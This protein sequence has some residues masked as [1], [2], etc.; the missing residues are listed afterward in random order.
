VRRLVNKEYLYQI[1]QAV[2]NPPTCSA[3]TPIRE[4]SS[5]SFENHSTRAELAFKTCKIG[6]QT[7]G[8]VVNSVFSGLLCLCPQEASPSRCNRQTEQTGAPQLPNWLVVATRTQASDVRPITAKEVSHSFLLFHFFKA[9]PLELSSVA[10][11]DVFLMMAAFFP[12]LEN[13]FAKCLSVPRAFDRGH[14]FSAW[15][16]ATVQVPNQSAGTRR[17]RSN[18]CCV[19]NLGHSQVKTTGALNAQARVKFTRVPFSLRQLTKSAHDTLPPKNLLI[20]G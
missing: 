19:F 8:A 3:S 12:T 10:K 1:L 14:L 4:R 6:R 16:H 7:N 9:G 13:G 20:I 11:L 5:A 17:P 15:L 18:F 2:S